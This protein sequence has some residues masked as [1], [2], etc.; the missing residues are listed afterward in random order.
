[1]GSLSRAS[2]LCHHTSSKGAGAFAYQ[3]A[4]QPTEFRGGGAGYRSLSLVQPASSLV[5]SLG[6]PVRTG[7][8]YVLESPV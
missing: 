6:V 7:I 5:A 1:M 4:Q 3:L 2:A 8:W